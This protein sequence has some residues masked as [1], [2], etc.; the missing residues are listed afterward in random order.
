MLTQS[1]EQAI[2]KN[3]YNYYHITKC[4]SQVFGEPFFKNNYIYYYDGFIVTIISQ[5][6][7]EIPDEE[8]LNKLVD[9]IIK[10][11]RPENI[12][13]WGEMPKLKIKSQK[14]Y[15]IDYKEYEPWKREL[16]I[17]AD[18]FIQSKKYKR[19]LKRA[20]E[21]GL[22]LNFADSKYYKHEYLKLL[23]NTHKNQNLGVKSLSYYC[24]FP[25]FEKTKFVE[26]I[27]D[28]KI[29]SIN[30]IIDYSPRY[31]CFAEIG[32]DNKIK[33]CSGLSK[34]LLFENYLGKT[35]FISWG[36]SANEG[37]FNFKKEFIGNTPF[38]FY[39]NYVYIQLYKKEKKSW[40]IMNLAK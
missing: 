8:S 6:I 39:D 16:V 15:L 5:R 20:K 26:V 10:R 13:I 11:H 17:H 29:V 30:I 38:C 1:D 22:K 36:G 28:N 19:Y 37:I 14:E 25:N 24:T 4:N 35:K 2:N 21:K 27:K 31:V 33:N 23:Y 18:K 12:I 7:N 40:W 34:A 32:Y 3:L 9:F